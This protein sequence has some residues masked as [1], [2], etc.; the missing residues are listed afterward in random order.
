MS[1]R[2]QVVFFHIGSDLFGGGSKMLLRLLRSLDNNSFEPILLSNTNDELCKRARD[3]GIRV[4]IIPFRGALNTFNRRLL[5]TPQLLFSAGFRILQFNS[6]A[7]LTLREADV[8][9]CENLRAVLTLYPY[10]FI[11][12]TPT[13]WNVGLGLEPTGK[14]KYL[15][16][17]GLQV[18]DHV[19]IESTEQ[20]SRVFT[21]NQYTKYN[22]KFTTF[23]KGIDTEKFDP[24]RFGETRDSDTFTIGTAASLTPR[25]G[26]HHLVDALPSILDKRDNVKLLIAGTAPD[27]NEDYEQSLYNQVVDYDIEEHVDFLGWVDDMPTYLDKLDVFVL[28]SLNEGIPGAVR[29]ALAMKVPV[30]ATNVGGTSDTI[31][32]SKTGFLI[33]PEDTTAIIDKID[34]LLTNTSI[35]KEMG[36]AAREHMIKDFS[37]KTYTN[38]YEK[39]LEQAIS[40]RTNYNY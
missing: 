26:I 6:G 17:L 38:N 35:R 10:L 30:V 3:H 11:S 27:G 5:T 39:F 16:S 13:I 9:W 7:Y 12:R 32:E 4:E 20:A 1:N 40:K 24:E 21:E 29:E 23:Y 2:I 31:I 18:I 22:K 15:K 34:Y 19:F 8:I 36:I 28:P 25:K 33:Q 14:V 37:I